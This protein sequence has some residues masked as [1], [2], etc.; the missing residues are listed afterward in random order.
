[1]CAN[2]LF[3]CFY[4]HHWLEEGS[5][6]TAHM[7]SVMHTQK[8]SRDLESQFQLE[9]QA[10]MM[11]NN[12]RQI[13]EGCML[14][15]LL[16]LPRTQFS[17]HP[18]WDGHWDDVQ[19][20]LQKDLWTAHQYVIATLSTKMTRQHCLFVSVCNSKEVQI[21]GNYCFLFSPRRRRKQMKIFT[22]ER[23]LSLPPC[24]ICHY[25]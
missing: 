9:V 5:T 1:M 25:Q 3:K 18:F 6:P 2:F 16:S 15:E 21:I 23:K 22:L 24:V 20:K 4:F 10:V 12:W 19:S 8:T 13:P 7:Q 14:F 11:G 17:W